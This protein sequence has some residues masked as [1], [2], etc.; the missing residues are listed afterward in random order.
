VG[1]CG[2]LR[3]LQ[4]VLLLNMRRGDCSKAARAR[5]DNGGCACA[6]KAPL[7]F[8]EDV[9]C[10]V[11]FQ[12]TFQALIVTTVRRMGD[13]QITSCLFLLYSALLQWVDSYIDSS[14]ID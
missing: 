12:P 8:Q 3:L 5:L 11:D 4:A 13:V 1:R 2:A 14:I 9:V 7:P 10:Y 6:I